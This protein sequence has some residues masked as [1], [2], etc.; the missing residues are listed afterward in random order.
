[1]LESFSGQYDR[2]LDDNCHMGLKAPKSIMK[3]NL[4]QLKFGSKKVLACLPIL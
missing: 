4:Y 1:M 3:Y 2:W